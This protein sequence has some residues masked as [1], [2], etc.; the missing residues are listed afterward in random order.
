MKKAEDIKV[1][2]FCPSDTNFFTVYHFFHCH[3]CSCDGQCIDKAEW[4][5]KKKKG[6]VR[7]VASQKEVAVM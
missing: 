4:L 6:E 7:S 1:F 5:K 3:L 2:I